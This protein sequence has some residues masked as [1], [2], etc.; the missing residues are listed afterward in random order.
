MRIKPITSD[1]EHEEA[2]AEIDQLVHR[3][4]AAGTVAADRI[5]IRAT[6]V[7]AYED[8]HWPI[9]PSDPV[10]AIKFATEQREV[11]A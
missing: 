6:L 10:E 11:H 9:D 5:G 3:I 7:E 2:V 1:A 8:R 4:P